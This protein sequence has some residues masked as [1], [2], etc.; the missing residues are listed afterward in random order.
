MTKS[1][2][3]SLFGGAWLVLDAPWMRGCGAAAHYRR[4]VS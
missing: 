2:Q 4:R 3:R 1:T